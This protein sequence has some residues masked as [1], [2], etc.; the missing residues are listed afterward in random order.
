MATDKLFTVC[1]ISKLNGEYK[2]RFAND[3]MRIKVLA[4]HDH[5]DIRLWDLETGMTKTDAVNAIAKLDEFQDVQAQAAIADYLDRN[6]KTVKVAAPKAKAT[7]EIHAQI[8]H[9][10]R[11]GRHPVKAKAT[12][13]VDTSAMEDAP[14]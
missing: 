4:K 10:G 8:H 7:D 11:F 13:K 5:E 3:T 12:A 2:V 1:G 14:F 9:S 6:V